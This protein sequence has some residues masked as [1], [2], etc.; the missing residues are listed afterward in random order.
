MQVDIYDQGTLGWFNWEQQNSGFVF[1]L[2]I[3][4]D[5]AMS[6]NCRFLENSIIYFVYVIIV[7]GLASRNNSVG[8]NDSKLRKIKENSSKVWQ[9]FGQ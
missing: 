4:H 8:H 7:T 6:K 2:H 1:G 5:H 9:E 3:K